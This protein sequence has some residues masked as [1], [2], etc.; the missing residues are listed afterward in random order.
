DCECRIKTFTALGENIAQAISQ[1]H[2]DPS[3]N[4]ENELVAIAN[5]AMARTMA[6]EIDNFRIGQVGHESRNRN[7]HI[8]TLQDRCQRVI[9]ETETKIKI[10]VQSLRHQS[11]QRDSRPNIS[12]GDNNKVQIGGAAN[13]IG[14]IPPPTKSKKFGKKGSFWIKLICGALTIF[15]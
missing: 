10:H 4:C 14:D 8:S 9:Q 3:P 13:S 5:G 12:I 15:L 11:Q 6:Q 1:I 7:F 2:F